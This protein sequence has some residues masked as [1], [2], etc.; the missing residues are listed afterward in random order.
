MMRRKGSGLASTLPMLVKLKGQHWLLKNGTDDYNRSNTFEDVVAEAR[1]TFPDIDKT[2]SGHVNELSL[3]QKATV[4]HNVVIE[5]VATR[6]WFDPETRT[7]H[8]QTLER[9]KI[10]PTHHEW[11]DLWLRALGGE[12]YHLIAQWIASFKA[13]NLPATMLYI[14]GAGGVGKSLI[15]RAIEEIFGGRMVPKS[16]LTNP[17]NGD[18]MYSPLVFIDEGWPSGYELSQFRLDVDARKFSA[19]SKHVQQVTVTGCARFYHAQNGGEFAQFTRAGAMGSDDVNAVAERLTA[20]SIPEGERSE[21]CREVLN[22]IAEQIGN[23][24]IVVRQV[25]EHFTHLMATV[26]LQSLAHRFCVASK[27]RE[28]TLGRAYQQHEAALTV[29]AKRIADQK[30]DE[31]RVENGNLHVRCNDGWYDG[32]NAKLGKAFDLLGAD[33]SVKHRDGNKWR[34]FSAKAQAELRG[35]LVYADLPLGILEDSSAAEIAYGAN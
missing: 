15:A 4:A 5:Y 9:T 18:R 3:R 28:A 19:N 31:V 13:L 27:G 11:V 8:L 32:R 2:E 14:Y 10:T 25:A 29:I 21:I 20:V 34:R 7:M 1:A 16:V 33:S 30:A 23:R 26:E 24:D 17:F 12:D 22:G 35:Y 6:N